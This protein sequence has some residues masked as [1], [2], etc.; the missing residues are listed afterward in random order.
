MAEPPRGHA[1]TETVAHHASSTAATLARAVESMV[2]DTSPVLEQVRQSARALE[3]RMDDIEKKL[4][5]AAAVAQRQHKHLCDTQA[6]MAQDLERKLD[7]VHDLVAWRQDAESRE[8]VAARVQV[9][10]M[11]AEVEAG[12]A[13]VEQAA[14]RRKRKAD[15]ISSTPDT[16]DAN[17]HPDP[18]PPQQQQQP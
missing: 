15:A 13:E 18:P 7:T 12:V 16:E 6:L 3:A 8:A 4:A 17:E 9:A 5:S 10:A 2:Q 14:R 11:L 1:L